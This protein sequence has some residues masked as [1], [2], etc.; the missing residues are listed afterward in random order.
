MREVSTDAD[1]D[2]D[3]DAGP[4]E[5]ARQE[6]ALL[7][8]ISRLNRAESLIE[9]DDRVMVAISGGKDSWALLHLL[10]AYARRVPFSFSIVAVNLDQG[11][12]GFPVEVLRSHLE[13]EGFAY[14]LVRGDTHGVVKA[15][16]PAGKAY[17]SLCSRL[18]RGML[19]RVATELGA[20]KIA[21]GH[22][23]DDVIETFLLNLIYAG[24][25]KAMPARLRSDSGEHVVIRPLATTAES[26]VAAYAALRGF[27]V[28]P[29]DLCGSQEN[30]RR[31]RMKQLVASLAREDARIPANMLAALGN[32]KPSHL[33]DAALRASAGSASSAMDGP[34]KAAAAS[35]S[36]GAGLI[37][38]SVLHRRRETCDE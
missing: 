11:H 24:Q 22:H 6:R 16:T 35:S 31:Q 3:T 32:V 29:C 7:R 23:R 15:N 5:A 36:A 30:L 18:R 21:L 4:G 9:P 19:Y 12:P 1:T 8:Q 10:R 25:L 26:A 27:P 20:T 28:V 33:W 2:A 34:S 13:R 14:H 17:C 38:L 37:P